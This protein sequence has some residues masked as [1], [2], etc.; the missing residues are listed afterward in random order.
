MSIFYRDSE[1]EAAQKPSTAPITLGFGDSYNP[2]ATPDAPKWFSRGIFLE[3]LSRCRPNVVDSLRYDVWPEY[4]KWYSRDEAPW[5]GD[6]QEYDPFH[7]RLVAWRNASHLIEADSEEPWI[8]RAVTLNLIYWSRGVRWDSKARAWAA[9]GTQFQR[10]LIGPTTPPGLPPLVGE[11]DGRYR[12]LLG[13]QAEAAKRPR[14]PEWADWMSRQEY[15]HLLEGWKTATERQRSRE[16]FIPAPRK[17]SGHLHYRWLAC[18]QCPPHPET[19]KALADEHAA[20]PAAVRKA[21]KEVAREIGLIL[22]KGSS[23]RPKKKA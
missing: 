23:G 15:D 6:L 16:G 7:E 20:S 3:E 17:K 11:L 10:L 12:P 21:L 14:P 22:R 18:W 4:Q 8:L 19:K 9:S 1:K 2:E 13:I 5:V